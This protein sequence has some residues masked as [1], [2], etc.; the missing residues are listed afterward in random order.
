L[1]VHSTFYGQNFL[2]TQECVSYTADHEKQ[3]LINSKVIL[4]KSI[5]DIGA[6]RVGCDEN[7]KKIR[8]ALMNA[9]KRQPVMPLLTPPLGIMYLAAYLREKFKSDILLINQKVDNVPND[10]LVSR[11]RE[12][13]ADVVGIGAMTPTA[14]VLPDI[15]SRIR[16][17]LPKALIVL[18]G[19]HVTVAGA[20]ILETT[21]AHAAVPGEGEPAFEAIINHYF[22]GS[23]LAD[24]PGIFWRN[25]QNEIITNPGRMP[26]IED[27][28]TLPL[29]AYDLINL[30]DYWTQQSFPPIP[31][32]R[33]LSLFSSRGC[34]YNCIYCHKIFG[35]RFRYHST[36]RMID[37]IKYFT[38]LYNVHDIEFLDDVFNMNH[39][40][41]MEFCG[42]VKKDYPRLKLALPNGVRTD[43]LKEEEIDALAEA[44]LYYASFALESGSPRIQK[45]IKKD[46]DIS[47]FLENVAL[48]ESRGIFCNG[49]AML[50]FPSETAVDMQQT[51]DVACR[52]RL[53]TSSFFTVTPFPNTELYEIIART[54]PEKLARLSYEDME[55]ADLTEN[56]SAEPDATLYYY[57]RLA[58]RRFYLNP[59]RAFRIIRDHPTPHLIP[60]YSAMVL[61][62]LTKGFFPSSK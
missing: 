12:F 41:L 47:K 43:I 17:A 35:R 52:S 59:N 22:D 36:D 19:P 9:G 1:A 29:P 49:F 38:R 24:V 20:K 45:V 60:L 27:L 4:V 8:I 6:A 58:N 26:F 54:H 50:G 56:F 3:V 40:R 28:D 2:D 18:G 46:L 42:R 53:H 34:P 10:R 16:T 23:S 48:A 62:K 15:V 55:Y 39:N 7:M 11:I 37:E 25:R 13:E 31:R 30:S 32:R 51:V 14:Q 44:G 61:K 21:E 57:Q 5:S 33:Y